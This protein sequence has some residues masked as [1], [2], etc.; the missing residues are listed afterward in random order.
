M[1]SDVCCCGARALCA[2]GEKVLQSSCMVNMLGNPLADFVCVYI[3][4]VCLCMHVSLCLF[5]F[6]L[7]R[8]AFG[9]L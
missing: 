3:V 4:C 8:L 6:A 9:R 5:V 7:S 1:W 2:L